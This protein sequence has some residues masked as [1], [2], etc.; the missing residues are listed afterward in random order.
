VNIDISRIKE[1]LDIPEFE[2][3]TISDNWK[4]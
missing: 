3:P 4:E 1:L 2:K